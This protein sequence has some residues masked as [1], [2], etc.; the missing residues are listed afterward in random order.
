MMI[1]EGNYKSKIVNRCSAFEI[2]KKGKTEY[3]LTNND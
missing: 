2:Q 1:L 3:R